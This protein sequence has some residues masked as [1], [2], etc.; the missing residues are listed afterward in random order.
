MVLQ[1]M[2]GQ[3]V[4][5]AQPAE[6]SVTIPMPA[7]AMLLSLAGDAG[8]L[9]GMNPNS[10]AYMQRGMLGRIFPETAHIR[11][12]VTRA[13]FAP[14]V[15][16][17]LQ[18][19]PDLIWQWGHL[20]DDLVAP[21]RNAGLPV[22]AL[23]YG[24]EERVKDWIRL[25]GASL[26]REEQAA[27]QLAWRSQVEQSIRGVTSHLQ[28]DERPRVMHFSRYFPSYQ[29]AG[30]NGNFQYDIHLA[31]GRNVAA[32]VGNANT[33]NIEQILAWN[34][35][36]ILLNNF[37]DQ[38]TPETIYNDPMLAGLD[39][40]RNHR[41]YKIPAGGYRWDPPN[42][43]S[44][45]YWQWLSVILHPDKFDWKLR[46]LIRQNYQSLYGY[47]ASEED[48]DFVLHTELNASAHLYERFKK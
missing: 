12:D 2:L 37:E 30:G 31:G 27:A 26:G 22:A 40:V 32:G 7:S 47:S 34:P 43:E 44:P 18:I 28:E 38:L 4:E 19:Q 46:D 24:T 29:V 3:R 33:V 13:G 15:E 1:D 17:L 42:Q 21:L 23:L 16:T 45:L 41:V 14:N 39:A 11:S 10:H 35:E 20:G 6:R 9:A 36:V 5:L 48:V 8:K 25:M